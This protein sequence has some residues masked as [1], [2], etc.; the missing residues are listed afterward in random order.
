MDEW[1]AEIGNFYVGLPDAP[2]LAVDMALNGPPA[3]QVGYGLA[4]S[5][6]K[7]PTPLDVYPPDEPMIG[8]FDG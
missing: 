4:Y 7:T 3:D 8:G 6:L 2:A 5:M 1:F